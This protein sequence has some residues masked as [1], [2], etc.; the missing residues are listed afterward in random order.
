[1]AEQTNGPTT[2][3]AILKKPLP[4]PSSPGDLKLGIEKNASLMSLL[5]KGL[6]SLI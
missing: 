3:Y 2:P 5:L 1:M 4:Y 6:H